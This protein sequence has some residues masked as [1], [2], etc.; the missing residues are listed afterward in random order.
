MASAGIGQE[1]EDGTVVP[2]VERA[3]GKR[4]VQD[5]GWQPRDL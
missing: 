3:G 4:M 1:M 5:I 2:N